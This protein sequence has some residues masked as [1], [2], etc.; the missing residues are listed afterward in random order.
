MGE[1]HAG[2]A[3]VQG[4]ITI[5]CVAFFVSVGSLHWGGRYHDESYEYEYQTFT[6]FAD[7]ATQ[8]S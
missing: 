1:V 6:L 3:K 7:I 4:W 5:F 2:G 8:K